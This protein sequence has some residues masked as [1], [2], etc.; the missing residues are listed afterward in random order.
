MTTRLKMHGP[1]NPILQG[2]VSTMA[3]IR[4]L[5]GRMLTMA[6]EIGQIL[7]EELIEPGE[8]NAHLAQSLM[9]A[10]GALEG[11]TEGLVELLED[12]T[13]LTPNDDAKQSS[14]DT[15]IQ[16][17]RPDEWEREVQRLQDAI[18]KSI[19]NEDDANLIDT[20]E[21]FDVVSYASQFLSE[22]RD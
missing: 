18:K 15:M 17:F 21:P 7:A 11:M 6:D 12:Q 19:D 4:T 10:M 1:Q 22:I 14:L 3:L 2:S 9:L 13:P 20:S 8:D 5:E 16:S